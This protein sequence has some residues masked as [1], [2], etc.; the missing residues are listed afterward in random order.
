MDQVLWIVRF[1]HRQQKAGVMRRSPLFF[2]TPA[3]SS[4]GGSIASLRPKLYAHNEDSF[5]M[6]PTT[7]TTTPVNTAVWQAKPTFISVLGKSTPPP[8]P[9]L[10]CILPVPTMSRS[11]SR[12]ETAIYNLDDRLEK[13]QYDGAKHILSNLA[14]S[15]RNAWLKQLHHSLKNNVPMVPPAPPVKKY[16]KTYFRPTFTDA[17]PLSYADSNSGPIAD[18]TFQAPVFRKYDVWTDRALA[19]YAT[20]DFSPAFFQQRRRK[21]CRPSSQVRCRHRLSVPHFCQIHPDV[22]TVPQENYQ[23]KS[24]LHVFQFSTHSGQHANYCKSLLDKDS[25]T[26]DYLTTRTPR[27][28]QDTKGSQRTLQQSMFSQLEARLKYGLA[29]TPIEHWD[30]LT[31]SLYTSWKVCSS[32]RP[33]TNRFKPT[34]DKDTQLISHCDYPIGLGLSHFPSKHRL[35]QRVHRAQRFFNLQRTQQWSIQCAPDSRQHLDTISDVQLVGGNLSALL[36]QQHSLPCNPLS[37]P[38]F[39]QIENSQPPNFISFVG[40][41]PLKSLR[42]P[43]FG[44]HGTSIDNR[45]IFVPLFSFLDS[46][47]PQF[48]QHNQV[49]SYDN[50]PFP[51]PILC[52]PLLRQHLIGY[53]PL[54][55]PLETNVHTGNPVD[56]HCGIS[57]PN[58]FPYVPPL[59]FTHLRAGF[60]CLGKLCNTF[61]LGIFRQLFFPCNNSCK[62][63]RGSIHSKT[64]RKTCDQNESRGH[65]K[66]EESELP[67]GPGLQSCSTSNLDRPLRP[68]LASVVSSRHGSSFSHFDP[69]QTSAMILAGP[70]WSYNYVEHPSLVIWTQELNLPQDAGLVQ[71]IPPR[72]C[73]QLPASLHDASAQLDIALPFREI[74]GPLFDPSSS[75]DESF[76]TSCSFV[77]TSAFEYSEPAA[78]SA[79][80]FLVQTPLADSL[81]IPTSSPHV[82]NSIVT[83][84]SKTIQRLN[85]FSG[86]FSSHLYTLLDQYQMDCTVDD[87]FH[88]WVLRILSSNNAHGVFHHNNH[89]YPYVQFRSEIHLVLPSTHNLTL[90]T[91]LY[92]LLH[93]LQSSPP[94]LYYYQSPPTPHGLCGLS[95]VH[96][97]RWALHSPFADALSLGIDYRGLGRSKSN[98]PFIFA[99]SR[100]LGFY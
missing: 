64:P 86:S 56:A 69:M 20:M 12:L 10:P 82:D 2:G 94:L 18:N 37:K 92:E 76:A 95:A 13:F 77:Q 55:S 66:D 72:Q 26:F 65:K 73:S 84:P 80:T 89:W 96:I 39:G 83:L 88:D 67:F 41:D 85:N 42:A 4:N 32:L 14:P 52:A 40:Y 90:I 7:S 53:G 78:S 51:S 79:S 5:P 60:S 59:S 81:S 8:R 62:L 34:A 11:E 27:T 75:S 23:Q 54:I 45:D 38:L 57:N 9:N 93:T 46:N 68:P 1:A 33:A 3:S 74:T 29:T 30:A 15:T 31:S 35:R 61:S 48:R 50:I 36:F 91:L 17:V 28:P 21:I 99:T 43:L 22:A 44:Q 63:S 97:L 25:T 71:T 6:L 47:A 58:L 100:P 24:S 16:Y 70:F 87:S 19:T 49:S 98:L